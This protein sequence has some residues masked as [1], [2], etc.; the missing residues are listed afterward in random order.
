MGNVV[1]N[2]FEKIQFM[3]SNIE[4]QIEKENNE[5]EKFTKIRDFVESIKE[6]YHNI[7]TFSINDINEICSL[8]FEEKGEEVFKKLKTALFVFKNDF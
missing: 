7:L 6:D 1:E 3:L 4:E 5:I 2:F 8:V